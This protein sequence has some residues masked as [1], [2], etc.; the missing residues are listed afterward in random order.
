MQATQLALTL[1]AKPAADGGV[2]GVIFNANWI[3]DN[4]KA[5]GMI[6]GA[7]V[8]VTFM[9]KA[10]KAKTGDGT[11]ELSKELGWK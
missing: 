8:A 1:L 11:T 7:V 3:M 2:G 4:L 6:I 5:V 10:H 9:M